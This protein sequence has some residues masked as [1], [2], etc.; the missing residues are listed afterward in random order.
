[1][2]DT[3]RLTAALD[4]I[5]AENRSLE[6]TNVPS[7]AT[8]PKIRRIIAG[9][10]RLLAAVDAAL[11]FHAPKETANGIQVCAF[12]SCA[13]GEAVTSPCP[14]VQAIS[15]ELLREETRT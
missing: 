7:W 6:T 14:E 9:S 3:E 2:P 5:R 1:V 13:Q 4:A 8:V 12:C 15:R 10:D 11:R